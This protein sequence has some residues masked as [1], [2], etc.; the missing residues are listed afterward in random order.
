MNQ[1]EPFRPHKIN[2]FNIIIASFIHFLSYYLSG[3]ILNFI[4]PHLFPYWIILLIGYISEILAYS[5]HFLGHRRVFLWWFS[6]HMGHHIN[7]YPAT[8]F[9][10]PYYQKAKRDNSK[11]YYVTMFMTPLINMWILNIWTL[12][13]WLAGFLTPTIL[14]LIADY[15]HKEFH[16]RNSHLEKYQWFMDLRCLHYYHHKND[17]NQNYAI[18]DFLIDFLS[19][20]VLA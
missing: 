4:Y 11:A 8:R 20:H 5:T 1:N 17:M 14:L 7:D 10:S 2:P 6:A 19:F 12:Y 13:M 15:I 16:T 18:A 3:V 9:L